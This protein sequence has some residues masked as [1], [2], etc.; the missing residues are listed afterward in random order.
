MLIFQQ[1]ANMQVAFLGKAVV[2][3]ENEKHPRPIS[4][5]NKLLYEV[6]LHC[7]I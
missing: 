7:S 3:E 4:D 2:F 1:L 6:I 5:K